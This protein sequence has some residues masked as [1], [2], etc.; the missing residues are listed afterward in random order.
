MPD[1]PDAYDVAILGAGAAGLMAAIR[2]S[3]RGGSRPLLEKKR[4]LGVKILISRGTRCNITNARGLRS[5][6]MVSGPIDPA[7]HAREAGGARSIQA[8]FGAG[9]PFLGP[10]LRAFGV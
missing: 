8:A 2:A 1:R 7:Y 5:L 4:R 3:E 10:A 9:G 6:R